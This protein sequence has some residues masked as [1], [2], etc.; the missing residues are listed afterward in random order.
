MLQLT[1]KDSH[2]IHARTAKLQQGYPAMAAD[3]AQYPQF[4]AASEHSTVVK[5]VSTRTGK[6][7]DLVVR[8]YAMFTSLAL[9]GE[10][11]I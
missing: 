3:L 8:Q 7:I 2:Y 6:S 9:L 1:P 10:P 11:Q 5:N 4:L